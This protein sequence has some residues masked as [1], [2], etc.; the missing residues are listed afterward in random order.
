LYHP[1]PSITLQS[2][3]IQQSNPEDLQ[4]DNPEGQTTRPKVIM[5]PHRHAISM[6]FCVITSIEFFNV[7][8]TRIGY[9]PT[10]DFNPWKAAV[11]PRK[12]MGV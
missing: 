3:S 7:L 9:I 6:S 12:I 10:H 2:L 11:K 8:P 5:S 4:K 1:I